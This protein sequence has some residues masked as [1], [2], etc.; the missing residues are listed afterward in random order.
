MLTPVAV[1]SQGSAP[2]Q[3]CLEFLSVL[4]SFLIAATKYLVKSSLKEEEI[5][6]ARSW[7]GHSPS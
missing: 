7:M 6:L 5:V 2:S 4:V 1:F 3:T